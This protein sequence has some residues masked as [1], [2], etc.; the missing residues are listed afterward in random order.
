[1]AASVGHVARGADGSEAFLALFGLGGVS[2]AT[3]ERHYVVG[4]F[5]DAFFPKDC[6]VGRVWIEWRADPRLTGRSIARDLV[7]SSG[8]IAGA[9]P[10]EKQL[11]HRKRGGPRGENPLS[12][13]VNE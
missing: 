10:G 1:M 12:R 13:P 6:L 7:Q 11:Q 2:L 9:G 3:A 4:H 5:V 8:T